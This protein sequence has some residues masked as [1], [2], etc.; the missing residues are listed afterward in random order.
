VNAWQ[1][2]RD[3]LIRIS[4]HPASQIDDILPHRWKAPK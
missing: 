4:T 3:V 2:L 1:Y